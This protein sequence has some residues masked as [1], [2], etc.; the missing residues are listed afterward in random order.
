[1]QTIRRFSPSFARAVCALAIAAVLGG[2][3]SGC[4][5]RPAGGWCYWHPARCW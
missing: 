4:V 1:M 3:L 2:A 5:V